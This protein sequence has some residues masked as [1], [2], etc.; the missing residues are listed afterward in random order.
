MDVLLVEDSIVVLEILVLLDLEG[1]ALLL[2]VDPL[3]LPQQ[4][5]LH[6]PRLLFQ[7]LHVRFQHPRLLHLLSHAPL[8]LS[9][10]LSVAL[11]RG[12]LL[13]DERLHSVN[14]MLKSQVVLLDLLRL[15]LSDLE[16]FNFNSHLIHH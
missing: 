14:I 3:V 7:L 2:L 10:S 6:V 8:R 16:L 9:D 15:V 13:L 11:H 1:D 5:P 12:L 4:T